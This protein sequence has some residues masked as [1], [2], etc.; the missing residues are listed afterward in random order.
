[1]ETFQCLLNEIM[2]NISWLKKNVL[3][4]VD[5]ALWTAYKKRTRDYELAI[6]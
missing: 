4:T 2:V 1:M 6:A 5:Y 3:G